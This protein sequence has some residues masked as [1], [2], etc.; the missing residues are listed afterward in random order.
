MPILRVKKK[1]PYSVLADTIIPY[2][3][4]SGSCTFIPEAKW[5][6]IK[7]LWTCGEAGNTGW[8]GMYYRYGSDTIAQLLSLKSGA[9]ASGNKWTW[10]NQGASSKK[11]DADPEPND[12][13]HRDDNEAVMFRQIQ[14]EILKKN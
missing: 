2:K 1:I 13:A 7:D 5:P 9:C 4:G 8:M 6:K 11:R 12:F 3:F 14:A 10:V